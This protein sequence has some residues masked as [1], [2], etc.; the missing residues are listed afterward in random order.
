[1]NTDDSFYMVWN[2]SGYNPKVKH[3]SYAKALNE[4]TRLSQKNPGQ[5]FFVL[6]S[7]NE[8]LTEMTVHT[9]VITHTMSP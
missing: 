7:T 4:A 1:M 6:V 9:N 2:P 5:R 3:S 8:V